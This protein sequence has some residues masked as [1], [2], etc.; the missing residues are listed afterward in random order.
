MTEKL[1]GRHMTKQ[2]PVYRKQSPACIRPDCVPDSFF[3]GFHYEGLFIADCFKIAAGIICRR[4]RKNDS[5]PLQ[6]SKIVF[7][8]AECIISTKFQ[9]TVFRRKKHFRRAQKNDSYCSAWSVIPDRRRC[10]GTKGSFR[11]RIFTEG[12]AILV[13]SAYF[14]PSESDL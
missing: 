10:K 11:R 5:V 14:F 12:V 7:C 6:S 4:Q 2:L 3:D 13:L 1:D 8:R 9:Y